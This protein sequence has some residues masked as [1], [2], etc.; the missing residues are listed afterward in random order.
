[1]RAEVSW[2]LEQIG[3]EF[4]QGAKV[5]DYGPTEG[6][7][8]QAL[9]HAGHTVSA[10]DVLGKAHIEGVTY[11]ERKDGAPD[12]ASFDAVMCVHLISSGHIGNAWMLAGL[13]SV[14][15][16][17]DGFLYAALPVGLAELH[18]SRK[19]GELQVYRRADVIAIFEVERPE[20]QLAS[21][22]YL[23]PAGEATW[24]DLQ[25]QSGIAGKEIVQIGLYAF[26]KVSL[27]KN[28]S[29]SGKQTESP[30]ETMNDDQVMPPGWHAEWTEIEAP[31]TVRE[32][33]PVR[34]AERSSFSAGV[35]WPVLG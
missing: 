8:L 10:V 28:R 5:L 20:L 27:K 32:P 7:E 17:T 35:A 29:G 24:S 33:E 1:M 13:L 26:R 16:R 3:K 6:D 19:Y 15:V 34:G 22:Q 2:I 21:E 23:T 14:F 30:P 4:P 18:I 25:E 11:F 31:A 9:V 12:K